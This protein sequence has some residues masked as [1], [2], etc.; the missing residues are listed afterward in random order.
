MGIYQAKR[1]RIEFRG[2]FEGDTVW[3]NLNQIAELFGRDKS[4]VSRHI[5]NVFKSGELEAKATVAKIATVQTA[6]RRDNP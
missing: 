6:S 4:A 2:D 1:G 5:R 3:G